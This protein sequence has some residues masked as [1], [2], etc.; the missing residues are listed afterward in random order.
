[1]NQPSSKPPN[2]SNNDS[3]HILRQTLISLANCLKV[4]TSCDLP[5]QELS[6]ISAGRKWDR[7]QFTIWVNDTQLANEE[8]WEFSEGE[9]VTLE[10]IVNKSSESQSVSITVPVGQIEPKQVDQLRKL[11]S[12]SRLNH[13]GTNFI[14]IGMPGTGKSTI[15][16][17]LAKRL[18]RPF[19]DLDDLIQSDSKKSLEEMIQQVGFEQFLDQEAE[20][21]MNFTQHNSILATGGSVVYRPAAMLSLQDRG[22]IIYLHTPIPELRNRLSD[23][24]QRGVVLEDSQSLEQLYQQREPFYECY[25]DIKIE[26]SQMT[27]DQTVDRIIREI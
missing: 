9:V 17:R 12:P 18:S 3:N 23:L 5:R 6:R 4:G 20:A 16:K 1:M 19:Y 27:L 15:G 11:W 8:I 14:L 21:A 25:Y 22:T 24:K 10:L 7:A 13:E 26:T 2:H